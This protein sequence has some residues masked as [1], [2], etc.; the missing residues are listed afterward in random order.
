MKLFSYI[1]ERERSIITDLYTAIGAFVLSKVTHF[2]LKY[3]ILNPIPTWEYPMKRNDQFKVLQKALNDG[4]LP[5][6]FRPK[7]A[8]GSTFSDLFVIADY[9]VMK[10]AFFKRAVA[11]RQ[12]SENIKIAI[13]TMLARMDYHK[14][15]RSILDKDDQLLKNGPGEIAGTADGPYDD[16]HKK[17]RVQ[18]HDTIKRL[19]G[20]NR[21]SEIIKESSEKIVA[22]LERVGSSAAGID[23]RRVFMNASLNVTSGFA[24]NKTYDFEDPQFE[25]IAEIIESYFAGITSMALLQ[26]S[27]NI[28]PRWIC[29]SDFYNRLWEKTSYRKDID[30]Q[31]PRNYLETILID[32]EQEPRWG[33]FTVAATI[34]AIFLAASDTLSVTMTWLVLVLA[35]NPEVQKKMLEEIS[36]AREIDADLKK[37]NCPFIRSVLLESQR[38]NPVADTLPHITTDDVQLKDCFIPKGSQLFA[39]L[40]AI[41]HDPKNFVEP[42]KFIPDRFIKNGEFVNN[43]KVCAFSV[44]LRD[45]IGKTLAQDEYFAFATTIVENFKI[46]RIAGNMEVDN[47]DNLRLPKENIRLQFVR[48]Q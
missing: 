41:M 6:I 43:P 19:V 7:L 46:N 26:M 42:G 47:A 21:I 13:S 27:W 33:Y 18:W 20:K 35:D 37:E 28:L 16:F 31:N 2:I 38:L 15:P 5:K 10:E 25:E 24:F 36:A 4:K 1:S 17:S 44:G 9:D 22:C 14:I 48:R 30:A 29:R 3:T 34:A 12:H 32:A 40:T 11:S 45:C 8:P 23:P 39:S